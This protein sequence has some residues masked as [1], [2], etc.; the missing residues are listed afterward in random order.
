MHADN[1][2]QSTRVNKI[3]QGH[4]TLYLSTDLTISSLTWKSVHSIPNGSNINLMEFSLYQTQ[5]LNLYMTINITKPLHDVVVTG[6]ANIKTYFIDNQSRRVMVTQ[7]KTDTFIGLDS[8]ATFHLELLG[9]Q[10]T[11]PGPKNVCDS[12]EKF[13]VE[14]LEPDELVYYDIVD[15]NKTNNRICPETFK[16]NCTFPDVGEFKAKHIQIR[17]N[18]K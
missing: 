14:I 4:C 13:C 9:I 2:E 18:D 15:V 6:K 5:H 7:R 16:K 12:I 8:E 3:T 17:K 1:Y 10:I 11:L